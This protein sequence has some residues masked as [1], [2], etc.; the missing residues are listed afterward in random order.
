MGIT[1]QVLRQQAHLINHLFHSPHTVGLVVKQVEIVQA[2]GDNIIHGSPLV[3]RCGRILKYHLNISD[4]LPVQSVW[5]LTGN[6]YALVL[7]FPTSQWINPDNRTPHGGLSG[8]RLTYQR[9][10]FPLVNIKGCVLN[11]ADCGL[12]LAEGN[13]HIFQG[14]ED[15][16]AALLINRAMLRQVCSPVRSFLVLF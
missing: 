13:I 5:N 1:G 8:T 9:K 10:G 11:S 3:Q 6:A 14:Q 4:D 15:L 2:F 16:L 12:S 7:N